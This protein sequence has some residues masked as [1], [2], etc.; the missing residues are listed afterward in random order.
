LAA[1]CGGVEAIATIVS[2]ATGDP[3][4][5]LIAGP[6]VDVTLITGTLVRRNLHKAAVERTAEFEDILAESKNEHIANE[7]DPYSS[8][9]LDM[10]PES[11]TDDNVQAESPEASGSVEINRE[12]ANHL[13]AFFGIST[14]DPELDD[15]RKDQIAALAR[16]S[17]PAAFPDNVHN[18]TRE[19]VS[20]IANLVRDQE[21]RA[22]TLFDSSK[23]TQPSGLSVAIALQ[24]T[25]FATST[26]REQY[27]I[28]T[29][30]SEEGTITTS[31]EVTGKYHLKVRYSHDGV[32]TKV[33]LSLV[34]PDAKPESVAQKYP[35]RPG[36]DRKRTRFHGHEL[37]SPGIVGI[38]RGRKRG[39]LPPG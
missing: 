28:N 25:G 2:V 12:N 29:E 16:E 36:L 20:R 10:E 21:E 30:L 5:A 6:A 9:W 18:E 1:V 11:D 13:H 34:D 23:N 38:S 22:I 4:Y 32:D 26:A 15:Q 3:T 35:D 37:Y 24:K 27:E 8:E 14:A 19:T 33:T 31:A 7:P 17:D 39:Q